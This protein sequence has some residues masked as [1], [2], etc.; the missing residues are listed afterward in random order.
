MRKCWLPAL[1]IAW[2]R[3]LCRQW[4][5]NTEKPYGKLRNW[6]E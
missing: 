2:I 1:M 3:K 5:S 6:K 4:Q